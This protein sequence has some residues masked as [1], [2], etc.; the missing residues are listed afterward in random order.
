MKKEHARTVLDVKESD[1]ETVI[2]KAYRKLA[3]RYHP[4]KNQGSDKSKKKFQEISEAFKCLTDPNYIEDDD[5]GERDGDNLGDY[6]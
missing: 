4:D 3:L 6:N 1:S 5:F 2:K